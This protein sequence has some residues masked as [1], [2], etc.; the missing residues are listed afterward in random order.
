MSHSQPE[1]V[2]FPL[3]CIV[4]GKKLEPVVK[5]DEHENNQPLHG[6]CFIGQGAYGSDFDPMDANL[7]LLVNVC[8]ECLAAK[9]NAGAVALMR[10]API[11]QRKATFTPYQP[12]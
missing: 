4:C 3:P 11:A 12:R 8:D 5:G 7:S 6:L 10:L 9:G 1:V 2:I